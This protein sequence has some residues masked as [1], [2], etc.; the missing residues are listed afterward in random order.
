MPKPS[1]PDA[2]R[3]I[4]ILQGARD[5]TVSWK[6]NLDFLCDRFP[7]HVVRMFPEGQH[8]LLNESE[9][10]RSEVLEGLADAVAGNPQP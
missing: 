9:P 1:P 3:P 8:Q 10:L 7:E 4:T 2:G 5:E 6:F